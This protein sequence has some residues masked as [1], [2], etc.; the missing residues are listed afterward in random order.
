MKKI[1]FFIL[2]LFLCIATQSF[3]QEDKSKA[4]ME[5]LERQHKRTY[6]DEE[7]RFETLERANMKHERKHDRSV[8]FKEMSKKRPNLNK[9]QMAFNEYFSEHPNEN[10]KLKEKYENW[11]SQARLYK[12]KDGFTLPFPEFDTSNQEL[13][14]PPIAGNG[15]FGTWT[16]IGPANMVKDAPCNNNNLVT[17]GFVDRVYVNPYNTQNLFA[18]FSYGGLWVS[19]D[20]GATWKLTDGAFANGTDSYAN[21]DYYY[22]EICAHPLNGSLV[23]AATEAGL[24]KSVDA[25]LTWTL[26][27]QLNRSASSANRP[28]YVALANDNQSIMLSTFGKKLYRSADGGTT[29]TVVFDNTSGGAN[30]RYTNQYNNSGFG[31]YDRNYNFFGLES[32][33]SDPNHFYVGTWN[34]SNQACIYHSTDKGLTFNLLTNL[35]TSLNRNWNKD[36]TLCLKTIASSPNKYFVYEQFA[37]AKPIY[38]YNNAGVLQS[39][40]KI[41]AYVEAYEIDWNNENTTYQGEYGVYTTASGFQKSTDGGATF[42]APFSTTSGNCNYIHPDLR[43]ISAVG[44]IVMIGNDSGLAMSTDGGVNIKGTGFEIN[45]M[46]IWG[47]SSS[48][49]SD[50]CLTGL[51][52][53]QTFVRPNTGVW[54]KIKGADA[55]VCS[56][57]TA[58]DH[59]LYYD[60]AY[61]VNKGYLNADGSVTESAVSALPDLG[62]L[63]FNPNKAFE[64]YGIQKSNENIMLKSIDN[65]NTASIF[66]DFGAKINAIRIAPND[67]NTLYVLVNNATIQKTSDGGSTWSSIVPS[68]T[69]T[70]ITAIEVGKTGNELWAAYGN[71]QNTVKVMYSTNGGSSWSNI[72][73]PNLPAVAVNGITY[74]RGTNGGVYILTITSGATKVWYR[75]NTMPQWEQLGSNLPIIG[76]LRDRMFTVPAKN[77]LRF[78]TSRGAWENPLYEAST[79]EASLSVDKTT[80]SCLRDSFQFYN[81]STYGVGTPT[82][83]WQ[84][85]G[86]SPASSSLENPKVTYQNSG[87]YS[88]TLTVTLGGT[89]NTKTSN[90]LINIPIG[91]NDCAVDTIPGKL[92]T[93]ASAGDFAQQSFPLNINSNTITLSAWIKPNG[94]QADYAGILFSDNGGATGLNFRT[95]NQIGYHWA[96][97]A[98][99]YSWN[100]GP[101]IAANVWSHV[102]LVV[103]PTAATV[104]VNGVAYTRTATHAV[105]NFNEIFQ[106]GIDRGN[107]SRNFKGLMDEISIYNKALSQNEIRELMNLTRNNPNTGSLPIVDNSLLSY[108]QFNEG[109]AKPAY[110]KVGVNHA[111]LVGAADKSSLSTAPVGGGTFQRIVVNTGGNKN[112]AT[113]GVELNFPT[114]GT[115]PNGD[116]VV[117]RINVA[118]DQLPT[119]SVLPNNPTSYY[120]IRNYGTNAT[121]SP[122]SSMKFSKVQGT[123][124][125]MANSPILLQLYKRTSNSDGTTWN[126]AIDDADL[127]TNNAGVGTVEFSTGLNNTTFSQFAIGV[128]STL[129]PVKLLSFNA[130]YKSGKSVQLAWQTSQEINLARYEIERSF[131]G[132]VFTKIGQVVATGATNYTFTDN[133]A[134]LGFNYYRLKIVDKDDKSTISVTKQVQIITKVSLVVTKG[135]YDVSPNP[136]EDGIFNFSFKGNTSETDLSFNITNELGQLIQSYYVNGLK[137]N[138]KYPILIKNSGI[139]FINITLADGQHFVEKVIV[140]LN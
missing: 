8:W 62:S 118:P 93:L 6:Q 48:P 85:P 94:I 92:L 45:S 122:L 77:K 112:F 57:N 10:S 73:T 50:I 98:G 67:P 64:I 90:N 35:N 96:D 117:S 103:T 113:P 27:P 47:F 128:N 22:G 61:G 43:G 2:P 60:W 38:K 24:L 15:T 114:T 127:V 68:T 119:M 29:W 126:S 130:I 7:E 63:Q 56:I 25:G 71:S 32:D 76:Y 52:H 12:D 140:N 3:A 74:Q 104:Y 37:N 51:D 55:G 137:N 86:G 79:V 84:F 131:D 87:V 59:W 46:D 81:T 65:M 88:A 136:S 41:N 100:G 111:I 110:D 108:Y 121:F 33:Y 99:S 72:T 18:G 116:L 138:E 14:N 11:Y 78:G 101:N 39:A 5:A 9:S 124:S 70:N 135:S 120:V 28:Y 75:N 36:T 129:L 58:D 34:S 82:F 44:N 26:C 13:K 133:D 23:L 20:Q 40:N 115:Y 69:Q 16:M 109:A 89:S 53:N 125:A 17:G 49:K 91:V 106:F 105:V 30:H 4:K 132:N 139:Y 95:N 102:A 54:K 66:K 107:T 21:R 19:T 1:I 97:G 80:T 134:A 83:A 31:L 42:S 123:T